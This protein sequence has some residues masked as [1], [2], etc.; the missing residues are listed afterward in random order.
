MIKRLGA[1]VP[2][3]VVLGENGFAKVPLPHRGIARLPEH[4]SGL[5]ENALRYDDLAMVPVAGIEPATY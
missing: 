4:H 1:C 5:V 3:V 2:S